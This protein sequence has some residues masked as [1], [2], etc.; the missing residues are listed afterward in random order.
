M[1]ERDHTGVLP[2]NVLTSEL[3]RGLRVAPEDL[4][5]A[6]G[7][8]LLGPF[9]KGKTREREPAELEPQPDEEFDED[10]YG[11][12]PPASAGGEEPDDEIEDPDSY[13][14]PISW[15]GSGSTW[16]DRRARHQ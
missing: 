9:R 15:A 3:M 12:L 1:L 16:A 11:P 4:K 8:D 5:P 14:V 10:V 6:A 2:D 7:K 13:D